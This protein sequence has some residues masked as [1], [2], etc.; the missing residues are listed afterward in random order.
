MQIRELDARDAVRYR[1]VRLHGLAHDPDAFGSSYEHEAAR[2]LDDFAQRIAPTADQFA[3]GCFNDAGVL[4]GIVNFSRESRLKTRHKGSIY[5]MYVEPA[6]R[7]TGVGRLLLSALLEQARRR[8]AGLEQIHLTVVSSNEPAQRL[9]RAMGFVTYGVEPR[10]L[11]VG[12][13][14]LDADLMVLRLT[15]HRG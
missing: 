6:V 7:G 14:Y 1:E 12:E 5:G 4:V 2:P 13:R 8:C 11:K 3:L 10:A 15:P 9:Y